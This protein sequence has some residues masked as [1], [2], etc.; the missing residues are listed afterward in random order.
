MTSPITFAHR[1]GRADAP[2]NTLEAFRRALDL[3]A[4]GLETDAWLSDDG[5]VVLHH[6]PALWSR[7]AGL[8]PW[9][10]RV[11]RTPAERLVGWGVVRLVD[12]Y[13][14]L[15]ADYELSIDVK[16]PG[17]GSAVAAVACEHG[18]PTRLWLCTESRRE[19]ASLRDAVP[20]ARIV[21]ST[22]AANVRGGFERHAADLVE[23]GVHAMN[24]HHRDWTA[25]LVALYHR[26]GLRTLAWDVQEVRDLRAAVAKGLDGV[27][28]DHVARMVAVVNEGQR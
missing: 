2:E 5:Q 16:G 23:L 12:L 15:G 13:A 20:E 14:A 25:G 28:S 4:T 19:L 11:D 1:G 10:H 3:G 27:Y 8:I 21:H 6:D 9:R 7:A 18:D 22:R 17:L 24:M 26:F